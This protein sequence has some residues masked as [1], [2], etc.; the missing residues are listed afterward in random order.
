MDYSKLLAGFEKSRQNAGG[1]K[2]TKSLVTAESS[3]PERS[4]RSPYDSPPGQYDSPAGA[5][6]SPYAHV[7]EPNDSPESDVK[8]EESTSEEVHTRFVC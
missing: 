8:K 3:E 2:S 4:V 7:P 6:D 5:Y 1:K